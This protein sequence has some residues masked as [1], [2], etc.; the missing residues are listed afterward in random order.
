[1]MFLLWR[2]RRV[3]L[4]GRTVRVGRKGLNDVVI[5][6][7]P[8]VSKSHCIIT[9]CAL[10][11]TSKNGT[12]VNGSRVATEGEVSL[13]AGDKI[14]IGS[15][16][17]EVHVDGLPTSPK[18]LPSQEKMKINIRMCSPNLSRSSMERLRVL[19]TLL[20]QSAS[21][22]APSAVRDCRWEETLGMNDDQFTAHSL[23]ANSLSPL[24]SGG[25]RQYQVEILRMLQRE[26]LTRLDFIRRTAGYLNRSQRAREELN[27]TAICRRLSRR[28]WRRQSRR[29]GDVLLKGV[30]PSKKQ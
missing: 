22:K 24:K 27:R 29:L 2:E 26:R 7:D 3:D 13:R 25:G 21:N 8:F 30:K 4:S 20:G 1:M 6:G 23:I 17:L 9:N 16:T 5:R 11:D 10:K 14:N 28:C 15:A 12:K 19:E 18:S